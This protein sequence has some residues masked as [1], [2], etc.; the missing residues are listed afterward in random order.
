[1]R[2]RTWALVALGVLASGGAVWAHV[3]TGTSV[4]GISNLV[5]G[6]SEI[7]CDYAVHFGDVAAISP[8]REMDLDSDY[9]VSDGEI[10]KYLERATP[11][12]AENLIL[13]IDG[14]PSPIVL[15]NGR[16]NLDPAG[17]DPHEGR[18]QGS[19]PFDI[20]FT[21]RAMF[22]DPDAEHELAYHDHNYKIAGAYGYQ[23]EEGRPEITVRMEDGLAVLKR[24]DWD[25]GGFVEDPADGVPLS[26][27]VQIIFGSPE[28]RPVR[29]VFEDGAMTALAGLGGG[30]TGEKRLKKILVNPELSLKFV[31]IAAAIAL[32]LGV[33]HALE[34][35]HGKTIVAAYLIGSRDTIWHALY[36][37]GIVTF[38]H[39][40]S[41]IILG[42]IALFASQYIM[43]AKLFPWIGFLSGFFITG[44]GVWLFLRVHA[45]KIG[46]THTHDTGGHHHE[47]AHDHGHEHHHDH[48]PEEGAVAEEGHRHHG[49]SHVPPPPSG[50]TLGS[51]LGLGIT[52]GIVPCPGALVILLTAIALNRI[53]FGLSLIVA[54]SVGLA[55]V[56][57]A[58]GILMVTARSFM[59]RFTSRAGRL[60][61]VLP[62]VSAVVI[63]GLGV[64]IAMQ[65]LISG[66]IITINL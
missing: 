59:D 38:T 11:A 34:P 19:F 26:R 14:V 2:G 49:H 40:I 62:M 33:V 66:G 16:V 63:S 20:R 44:I 7:R 32:F 22:P 5:I 30:L 47:H 57:I 45:G 13:E 42:L 51:L 61:Q 10:E 64:V 36:L 3:L 58:I 39:T 9:M 18:S 8:R 48:G 55:A 17:D 1:M 37:G 15:E 50:V 65:A 56:L 52:G 46:H 4:A 41:V 54:F 27:S 53:V 28:G 21:F 25:V 6:R 24:W 31:L 60:T 43:P 12:L 29:S 35:G 23:A